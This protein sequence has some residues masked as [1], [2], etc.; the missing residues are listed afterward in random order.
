MFQPQ[1][2][3]YSPF[4]SY[5]VGVGDSIVDFPAFQNTVAG[6]VL[7][8]GGPTVFRDPI[9]SPIS[10]NANTTRGPLNYNTNTLRQQYKMAGSDMEAQE[11]AARHFKPELQVC[12]CHS[13]MM[14][15][16]II[17][18]RRQ[19]PLVGPKKSS[20]AITEEYA[21]ADPIYVAKTAVGT[22]LHTSI[23]TS[24]TGTR[25]YL[26]HTLIFVPYLEMETV[27]GGVSSAPQAQDYLNGHA[28]SFG[29][30]WL[31]LYSIADTM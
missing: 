11:E 2:T 8:S 19:G 29:P 22:Y 31:R 6:S 7:D 13:K 27:D 20:R 25:L 28:L 12:W 14:E 5:G 1:P 26:K 17:A 24:L 16:R 23:I 4:A 9:F 15:K 10:A 30:T 18:D 21:R 3:P